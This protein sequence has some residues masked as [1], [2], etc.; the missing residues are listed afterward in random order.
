MTFREKIIKH[1]E[2][3]DISKRFTID[4]LKKCTDITDSDIRNI[5]NYDIKNSGSSNKNKKFLTSTKDGNIVYYEVT[6]L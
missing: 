5:T 4:D 2:N 3:G 1:I 6:K